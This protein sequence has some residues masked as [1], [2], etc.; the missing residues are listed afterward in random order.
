MSEKTVKINL[1]NKM[2]A[3]YEVLGV[4]HS[5]T[6]ATISVK[7][8]KD[9]NINSTMQVRVKEKS[10]KSSTIEI[11]YGRVSE[12]YSTIDIKQAGILNIGG[13]I[14]VTANNKMRATYELV[15]PSLIELEQ[16][17]LK[18]AFIREESPYDTLNYGKANT[19][20][21]NG[22]SN[23]RYDSLIAFDA[24]SAIPE[25]FVYESAKL[26]LH[27][28]GTSVF[29]FN[30]I[31]LHENLEN[32]I[33]NS[34]TYL[35][36]P[37]YSTSPIET[38]VFINQKLK[39]IEIELT[40]EVKRWIS[41]PSDNFGLTLLGKEGEL[42]DFYSKESLRKPQLLISGY[43]IGSSYGSSRKKSTI[44]VKINKDSVKNSTIFIHKTTNDS[45]IQSTL[46]VR[47]SKN[48][49]VNSERK[50]TIIV[51]PEHQHSTI[52]VAINK[53]SSKHSTIG[54]RVEQSNQLSSFIR[55]STP[56]R[57]GTIFIRSTRNEDLMSIID[58]QPVS[59][60]RATIDV[61]YPS[62]TKA[63]IDVQPVSN[64]KATIDVVYPSITKATI[65]TES[66]ETS[67]KQAFI[68][69]TKINGKSTIFVS[70]T[71]SEP[72][73]VYVKGWEHS[74]K[75]SYIRIRRRD[76]QATINVPYVVDSDKN[77][78]ITVQRT[79]NSDTKGLLLVLDN[80]TTKA[81]IEV[82]GASTKKAT[83]V[84]PSKNMPA[85]ISVYYYAQ[86]ENVATLLPRELRISNIKSTILVSPTFGGYVYIL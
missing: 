75:H 39:Y 1:T 49:I 68:L 37:Q 44:L 34:V 45:V 40:K 5:N 53:E 57:F 38:E 17:P 6:K 24:K 9:S 67:R 64:K 54:V 33:E 70:Y 46:Y 16:I 52:A 11:K 65:F 18:D 55:I 80:P 43:D 35:S 56:F 41:N 85:T 31:K 23:D 10:S 47:T 63:T 21:V 27:Y 4:S 78:T 50:S 14:L 51:S 60:C 77:A 26:R 2:R 74:G 83:I 71:S 69:V 66:V 7:I 62:I 61:V 59:L 73:T 22:S 13:T 8:N 29:D 84:V 36:K 19:L 12:Q 72:S 86:N 30:S 81:T 48:E 82:I 76:W 42:W 28:R 25:G 79:E 3:T 58:V 20:L 15:E 32:W